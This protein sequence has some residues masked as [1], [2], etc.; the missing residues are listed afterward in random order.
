MENRSH[1]PVDITTNP[2]FRLGPR[3]TWRILWPYI[4]RNFFKQVE[5]I[6]FIV[7][8]LV[9]FQWL[10]LQL[11]LVFALMIAAG[12]FVVAVGLMFFMEGLR[13]GLMP[14]GEAIGSLLPRTSKLPAILLFAFLLGIGAN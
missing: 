13:L 10:V 8:Y 2:R 11:P 12:I 14:L 4:K 6:W 9:I 1:T 3:D 7:T 5:G